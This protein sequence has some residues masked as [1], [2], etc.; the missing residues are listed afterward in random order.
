METIGT[1]GLLPEA[2]VDSKNEG[3]NEPE[4]EPSQRSKDNAEGSVA[5]ETP[6]KEAKKTGEKKVKKTPERKA[7]ENKNTGERR[8]EKKPSMKV[9]KGTA[10]NAT[11]TTTPPKG[12]LRV[13][14]E[15]TYPGGSRCAW[16]KK[17]QKG[18][19]KRYHV[20]PS[21]QSFRYG[22]DFEVSGKTK[23]T[24]LATKYVEKPKK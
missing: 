20:N 9:K 4:P 1:E 7:R 16:L 19:I 11:R 22:V 10:A 18:V 23:S 3:Q 5:E 12:A 15:F 21:G 8:V 6:E 24:Q 2:P 14:T 17:G 13:G